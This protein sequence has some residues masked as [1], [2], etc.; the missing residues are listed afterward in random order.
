MIP[1]SDYN[2]DHTASGS[3]RRVRAADT[4]FRNIHR[5]VD[6]AWMESRTRDTSAKALSTTAPPAPCTSAMEQSDAGVSGVA[7]AAA[8]AAG[9]SGID[10]NRD[11]ATGSTVLRR[12]LATAPAHEIETFVSA[13]LRHTD[14]NAASA[15]LTTDLWCAW[16]DR[17][18]VLTCFDWLAAQR[19]RDFIPSLKLNARDGRTV[20]A[21]QLLW[22]ES[23]CRYKWA[24]VDVGLVTP[25]IVAVSPPTA[26]T[27]PTEPPSMPAAAPSFPW[28]DPLYEFTDADYDAMAD[29]LRCVREAGGT[30]NH[31][32]VLIQTP[33]QRYWMKVI[34]GVADVLVC[35]DTFNASRDD[36]SFGTLMGYAPKWGR[37]I[38]VAFF[39]LMY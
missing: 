3:L 38:P 14:D 13:A 15:S 33:L 2:S 19:V 9:D 20:A 23:L 12:P 24:A 31:H 30:V 10:R 21:D 35:D 5:R 34:A 37:H 16:F 26:A 6:N 29:R 4:L 28:A 18:N 7:A 8:S 27:A 11:G 1:P 39:V 36:S 32:V 25:P 22:A 17:P